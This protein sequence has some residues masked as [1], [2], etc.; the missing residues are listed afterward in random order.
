MGRN[1]WEAAK[2]E[3]GTCTREDARKPAGG[4]EAA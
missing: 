1:A 4:G 2:A 3:A